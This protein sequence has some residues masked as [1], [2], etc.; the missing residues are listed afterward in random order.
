MSDNRRNATLK[1]LID[2]A[3]TELMIKTS[4]EQ[5]YLD[6]NTTLSSK[7]AEMVT[8][9]NLR[10]K[11]TDVDDKIKTVTDSLNSTSETLSNDISTLRSEKAD[12]TEVDEKINSTSESLSNDISTL[13]SNTNAKL[14]TKADKAALGDLATKNKVAK[15]DLDTALQTELDAKATTADVDTKIS[16]LQS[17]SDTK[18][19]DADKAINLRPTQTAVTEQIAALKQ[20]IM[21][22]LPV[23][24]YD[25]FTELATYIEKHQDA[26][27][28]LTAA[29]GN[30]ADKT[31]VDDILTVINGLGALAKKDK[32]AKDDLD[33]S[34]QTELDAKAT[35]E[36][37]NTALATKSDTSHEHDDRYYTESEIDT[38]LDTKSNTGHKHTKADITDFPTSLP[39]SDVYDWAKAETKPSYTKDEVGLDKAGNFKAVSTVADQGLTDEEKA[40][41]RSNI[42]AGASSFSGNYN[43]L[44]NKP[45]LGTAAAMNVEDLTVDRGYSSDET[46]VGTWLDGKTLYQR[47][48]S[49]PL[50]DMIVAENYQL[51][52]N[53]MYVSSFDASTDTL[54]GT[55]NSGINQYRIEV[56]ASSYGIDKLVNMSGFVDATSS[57]LTASLPFPVFYNSRA[58]VYGWYLFNTELIVM[59]CG[60]QYANNGHI[61]YLTIQYTK[62]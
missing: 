33:A 62:K 61:V 40:N 32:V 37:M 2:A 58:F 21:G 41:A 31:V 7:M 28:A 48:I 10:D 18:F 14:E 50:N 55:S 26:A 38:K 13:E 17:S 44:S 35:T 46:V 39:A 57:Q 12:K 16:T 54:A 36:A 11:K 60:Q 42:G 49:V 59:C 20:E 5:I 56:D 25:T 24:A 30:K 29:V 4:G 8:A 19:S 1:A 9:I 52:A 23:E 45:T 34:L 53:A 43:D 15:D 22:D 47:T 6:D 27:D 51:V 3:I